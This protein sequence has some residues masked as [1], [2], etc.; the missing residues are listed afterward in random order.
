MCLSAGALA[1][2]ATTAVAGQ[3]T[4]GDKDEWKHYPLRAEA[5]RYDFRSD[6]LRFKLRPDTPGFAALAVDSLGK[7]NVNRNM[8]AEP[9]A[10]P[11]SHAQCGEYQRKLCILR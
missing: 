8:V 10:A 2:V 9:L 7:G 11:A 5:D 1:G 4:S 6:H 3:S